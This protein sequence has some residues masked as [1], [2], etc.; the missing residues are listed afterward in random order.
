MLVFAQTECLRDEVELRDASLHRGTHTVV[1]LQCVQ[2]TQLVSEQLAVGDVVHDLLT[3]SNQTTV[4]K[5]GKRCVFHCIDAIAML[6]KL[7]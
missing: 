4:S 2:K 6:S 7:Y 1:L 3:C 5:L